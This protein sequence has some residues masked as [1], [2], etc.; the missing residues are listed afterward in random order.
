MLTLTWDAILLLFTLCVYSVDSHATYF[1]CDEYPELKA[2]LTVMGKTIAVGTSRS[3]I[4]RRGSTELNSGDNY[5]PGEV[6]TVSLSVTTGEMILETSGSAQFT[7]GGSCNGLYRF[8]GPSSTLLM[9]SDL[10]TV[11]IWA[12]W[13]PKYGLVTLTEDFI[14]VSAAYPTFEPSVSFAPS[15]TFE[16]SSPSIAPTSFTTSIPTL[17]SSATVLYALSVTAIGSG[18]TTTD[19]RQQ[20]SVLSGEYCNHL[21]LGVQRCVVTFIGDVPTSDFS[22]VQYATTFLASSTYL[23]FTVVINDFDYLEEAENALTELQN[24]ILSS[25]GFQLDFYTDSGINITNLSLGDNFVSKSMD[26]ALYP[27]SCQINSELD[28]HWSIPST[29]DGSSV[30]SQGGYVNAMLRMK[31]SGKA[32]FAGGIVH[33]N[34]Q[35]MVDSPINTVYFYDP[36]GKQAGMYTINDYDSAGIQPDVRYRY[37]TGVSLL[38]TGDDGTGKY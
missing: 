14:L 3:I 4:V 16:P 15:M 37:D 30:G 19:L 38:H 35:L 13:A 9:P 8:Y 29:G 28:L 33:N 26:P 34:V 6:L 7:N 24:Y 1:T 36:Y 22:W 27:K 25:S 20:S 11:K 32:W 31:G 2:G 23:E 21:N 5:I 17:S 12:G 18:T 10:S